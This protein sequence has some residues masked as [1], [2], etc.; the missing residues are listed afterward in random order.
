MKPTTLA[1]AAFC[2][3]F[4]SH[5]H[6]APAQASG[7]AVEP[8]ARYQYIPPEVGPACWNQLYP[9]LCADSG[10]QSPFEID[11]AVAVRANLPKLKFHYTEGHITNLDH[12]DQITI[13][14]GAGIVQADP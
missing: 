2:M 1:A 5:A 3:L 13:D 8:P 10:Y 11:P 7:C 14:H 9:D 6:S 12:G 4:L